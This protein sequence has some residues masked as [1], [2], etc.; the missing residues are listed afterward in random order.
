MLRGRLLLRLLAHAPPILTAASSEGSPVPPFAPILCAEPQSSEDR[1][2]H[3][4]LFV[5]THPARPP[6]PLGRLRQRRRPLVCDRLGGRTD[7]ALWRVHRRN[8]LVA[9]ASARATGLVR[10]TRSR[11]RSA[12]GLRRRLG[13]PASGRA[14]SA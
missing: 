11:H 3:C 4:R 5:A 14:G 2:E 7:P 10:G 13:G 6:R 12:L 9:E 1:N 8:D